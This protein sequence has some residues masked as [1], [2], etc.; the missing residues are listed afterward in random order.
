MASAPRL[1][2]GTHVGCGCSIYAADLALNRCSVCGGPLNAVELDPPLPA[3]S[4]A[5]LRYESGRDHPAT[6][7]PFGPS[8][9]VANG[10]AL[11]LL[12]NALIIAVMMGLHWLPGWLGF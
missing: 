9:G 5:T 7:N 3:K 12:A 6:F 2:V 11:L 8:H 1:V 10:I 4:D